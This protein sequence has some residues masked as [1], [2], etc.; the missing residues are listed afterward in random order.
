MK[1]EC[2]FCEEPIAQFS[3]NN[4]CFKCDLCY[5]LDRIAECLEYQAGRL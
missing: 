2:E 5:Q 4:R 3:M 1:K